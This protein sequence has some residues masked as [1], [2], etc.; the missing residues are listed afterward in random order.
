M[1]FEISS[2]AFPGGDPIPGKYARAGANLNPPLTWS[3]APNGTRELALVVEDP[4]APG[5]EPFVHWIVC[6][7][8]ATLVGLPEGGSAQPPSGLRVGE[9]SFGNTRYDGPAPPPGRPHHYH[10]KLY[11]LDQPLTIARPFDRKA[12]LA[13]SKGH[14]LAEADLVGTFQNHGAGTHPA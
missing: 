5:S 1:A 6:G 9:N 3:A 2:P 11:A 14:V 12:L 4:D 10:F 13:A 7:L 8:P